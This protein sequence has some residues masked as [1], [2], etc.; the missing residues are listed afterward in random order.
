MKIKLLLKRITMFVIVL[1]AFVYIYATN[2]FTNKEMSMVSLSLALA[3]QQACNFS[4]YGK[5]AV[6]SYR[7]NPIGFALMYVN[8]PSQVSLNVIKGYNT[9]MTKYAKDGVFTK[10]SPNVVTK[11]WCENEAYNLAKTYSSPILAL[12]ISHESFRRKWL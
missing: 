7:L 10:G 2:P 1:F 3:N 5:S 11:E 8:R 4:V 9:I 12:Q 6:E